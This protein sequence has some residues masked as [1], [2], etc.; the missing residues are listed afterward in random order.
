MTSHCAYDET[1]QAADHAQANSTQ[2]GSTG[3]FPVEAAILAR[4]A[5]CQEKQCSARGAAQEP[6]ARSLE[7]TGVRDSA[8]ELR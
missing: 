5:R 8:P 1:D 7:R 3:P 2:E 4:R 6:D